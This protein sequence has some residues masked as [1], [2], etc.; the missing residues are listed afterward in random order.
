M[1]LFIYCVCCCR[2]CCCG[3]SCFCGTRILVF[4]YP[5]T[6][7][8]IIILE[9]STKVNRYTV[10]FRLSMLL[11]INV[12]IAFIFLATTWIKSTFHMCIIHRTM[13]IRAVIICVARVMNCL[14]RCHT[15]DNIYYLNWPFSRTYTTNE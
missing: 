8:F 3:C 12:A 15:S 9:K 10:S 7:I 13:Q 2:N 1:F 6:F 14:R 4:N 5:L 11:R